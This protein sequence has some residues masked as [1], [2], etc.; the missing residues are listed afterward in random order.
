MYIDNA[1]KVCVTQNQREFSKSLV[2]THQINASGTDA[3][4]K[5]VQNI[6]VFIGVESA[7]KSCETC[8]E[9]RHQFERL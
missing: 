6:S 9:I 2:Y 1:N 3:H 4:Y 7:I 5:L 8:F